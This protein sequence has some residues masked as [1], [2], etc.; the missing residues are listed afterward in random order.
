METVIMHP[1]NEEQLSALKV[2]AKALK[3]K[4]E[5]SSRNSE[6]AGKVN[7]GKKQTEESK[8]VTL[9]PKKSLEENIG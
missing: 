8:A 7:K 3:I 1:K 5:I 4:F 9:D 6:F 2:F